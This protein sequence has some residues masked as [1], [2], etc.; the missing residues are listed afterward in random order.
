[1]DLGIDVPSDP[2]HT[3]SVDVLQLY[4]RIVVRQHRKSFRVRFL[5]SRIEVSL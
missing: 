3:K 2:L 4:L 5:K 1:M